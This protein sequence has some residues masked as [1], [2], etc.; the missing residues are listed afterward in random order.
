M[1]FRVLKWLFLLLIR[2]I[3]KWFVKVFN[4]NFFRKIYQSKKNNVV[5]NHQINSVIVGMLET[6]L[7][8][9]FSWLH[10]HDTIATHD[11]HP[12]ALRFS[13]LQI[14]VTYFKFTCYHHTLRCSMQSSTTMFIKGSKPRKTPEMLLK[15]IIKF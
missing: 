13:C 2:R 9:T 3:N 11:N 10:N 7:S 1:L 15:M 14:A 8:N 6:S 4:W 5:V 12:N